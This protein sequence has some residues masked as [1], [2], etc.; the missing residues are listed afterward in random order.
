MYQ[1]VVPEKIHIHPKEGHW[2]FLGDGGGGVL[3]T[4]ISWGEEECKTKNLSVGGVW[5]LNLELR[6]ISSTMVDGRD[7]RLLILTMV[8]SD[9]RILRMFIF[10][11]QTN[12]VPG[13]SLLALV[14]HL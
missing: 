9:W 4:G 7:K 5:I 6:N 11:S 2:N 13:C 10:I 3:E 14:F 8:V 12:A 1:C